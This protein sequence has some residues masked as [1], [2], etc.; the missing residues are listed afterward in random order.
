[1]CAGICGGFGIMPTPGWPLM[2]IS[3]YS[4]P[5]AGSLRFALHPNSCV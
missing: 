4:I 2:L 3:V 1:M 5:A